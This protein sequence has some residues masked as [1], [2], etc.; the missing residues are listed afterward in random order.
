M[1]KVRCCSSIKDN[2]PIY[3]LAVEGPINVATQLLVPRKGDV[4]SALVTWRSA[5]ELTLLSYAPVMEKGAELNTFKNFFL[6]EVNFYKV[7]SKVISMA[8]D[9]TPTKRQLAATHESKKLAT[10]EPWSK[11]S[12]KGADAKSTA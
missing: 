11:R 6:E 5:K 4:I 1:R 7:D 3:N 8:V 12:R 10:P 9:S 2:D